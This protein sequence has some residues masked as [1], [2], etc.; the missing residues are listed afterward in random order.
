MNPSSRHATYQRLVGR[1]LAHARPEEC[2]AL[3]DWARRLIEIAGSVQM[4]PL[5]AQQALLATFSPQV[6][7][8]S[9]RVL[10][11]ELKRLGWDERDEFARLGLSAVAAM[12]LIGSAG[13]LAFALAGSA[14]A[15][16]MWIVFGGGVEFAQALA[17]AAGG[18]SQASQQAAGSSADRAHPADAASLL[19]PLVLINLSATFRPE[20]SAE[21]LYE[22]ARG[23]WRIGADKRARVRHAAAVADGTVREVYRIEAWHPA[24]STPYRTRSDADVQQA[25]RWEFTGAVAE[26]ALRARLVGASMAEHFPPGNPN[27]IRYL[28][29]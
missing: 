8:G 25:G 9:L 14:V 21:A 3:A 15:V 12:A 16:P 29:L 28:N 27:P 23:V 13:A 18:A 20:W 10:G 4:P 17:D 5:K 24:G 26:G 11:R 6:S 7:L 2:E 1:M 22:A 19:P